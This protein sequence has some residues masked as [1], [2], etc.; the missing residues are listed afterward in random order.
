MFPGL[1]VGTYGGGTH[2]PTQRAAL[3]MLGCYGVGGVYKLCELAAATALAAEISL[4]TAVC[5]G[6][7]VDAHDRM[8]RNRY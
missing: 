8:G 6:E 1:V 3:E 7:W 4:I 2:L 5:A